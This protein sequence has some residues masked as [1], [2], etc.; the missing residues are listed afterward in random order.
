M[1]AR[2]DLRAR[3]WS[4]VALTILVGL[5]GA[6]SMTLLS[7]AR[8]SE[9]A[10]GRYRERYQQPDAMVY[11]DSNHLFGSE[12]DLDAASA[13]PEVA[14]TR[15]GEGFL[16]HGYRGDGETPLFYDD[17]PEATLIAMED[18]D[19]SSGAPAPRMVEGRMP[20][21]PDEAAI[22]WR[23][24]RPPGIVGQEI[25]VAPLTE[26][27]EE[28]EA[29]VLEVVGVGLASPELDGSGTGV[30]ITPELGDRLL[31]D[32]FLHITADLVRLR[33]GFQD[34]PAYLAG[35]SAIDRDAFTFDMTGEAQYVART[36]GLTTVVMRIAGWL[37]ALVGILILGQ[38][39]ARRSAM[40]AL[41]TPILR[42]LGM[43]R[44][45]LVRSAMV[46]GAIVGLGGAVL[47]VIGATVGSASTPLGL[48]RFIEPDPGIAIDLPLLAIGSVVL[49][50]S[51]VLCAGIPAMRTSRMRG[52]VQG[53]IEYR[54]SERPSRIASAVARAWPRPTAVA[55]SRLALEPGHG[56]TALPVR[57]A[58]AGLA[59]AVAAMIAAFGFAA[60][61]HHFA[62][63]PRLWGADFD[64]ASGHPFIGDRFQVEAVSAVVEDPGFE[65]VSAGNFQRTVFVSGPGGM[66]SMNA[67]A[68]SPERGDTVHPTMLEGRWP[69]RDDEIALGRVSLRKAGVSVGGRIDVAAGGEEVSMK[70]VGVPVFPDFGFGPGFGQGS[71]ITMDALRR[72]FPD[73][74]KNLVVGRYAP[75]VVEAEVLQRVNETLG[76]MDAA[77]SPDD[78]RSLGLSTSAA[79][80]SRGVPLIAAGLLAVAAFATLVHV[81]ITSMRRRRRDLAVLRTLGFVGR[82]VTATVVWQAVTLAG[83]ALVI[84][85]PIGA[86]AGRFG[87]ELFADRLGV[88]SE[89]VIG[90]G[91]VLLAVPVTLALAA[92]VSL[93]PGFAARRARPAAILRAE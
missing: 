19:P 36:T 27:F 60:S 6:A 32:G 85:I 80:R 30:W 54:G 40:A 92:I 26:S 53:A 58:V 82:Q 10:Y 63:T 86:L 2:A 17:D 66:Q 15:R 5:V 39:V 64:F 71:G 35:I 89:P 68:L 11:S 83:V 9:T 90:V 70:V 47:A 65:A 43:R 75:G 73:D 38:V 51:T 49:V 24:D 76:P 7:G 1:R 33:N 55:G 25:V 93:G 13:L 46:P 61:M 22:S 3:P 78:L 48:A 16:A 72:F 4:V 77:V 20:T 57:S 59:L 37:T 28:G 18:V 87:W 84:G 50:G 23:P 67:W 81:L 31:H 14:S 56:R 44:G 69:V 34:L 79:E 91:A 74:T 41:D 12:V 21:S 42:A 62:G 88:V 8:R 45:E 52:G 29:I